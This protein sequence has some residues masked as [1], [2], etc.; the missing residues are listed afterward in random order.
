MV[1]FRVTAPRDP[2][3]STVCPNALR[4]MWSEWRGIGPHIAN[5]TARRHA[6][7]DTEQSLQ[8]VEK[9]YGPLSPP[10]GGRSRGEAARL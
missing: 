1:Y 4:D 2:G 9:V 8:D 5:L 3:M 7:W 6:A 10:E